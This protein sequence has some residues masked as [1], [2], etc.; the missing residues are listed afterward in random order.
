M[1]YKY[2]DRK[3]KDYLFF[4]AMKTKL[5]VEDYE[6]VFKLNNQDEVLTQAVNEVLNTAKMEILDIIIPNVEQSISKV[7]LKL[8]NKLTA[9]FPAENLF[10]NREWCS[11]ICF[12]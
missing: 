3:G 12:I 11:D 9:R 1:M 2:V 4:N 5:T 6:S 7:T 8:A 10:P